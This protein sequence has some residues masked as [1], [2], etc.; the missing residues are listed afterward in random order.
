MLFVPN[1]HALVRE[2]LRELTVI[3][4]SVALGGGG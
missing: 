2:P 4:I 1:E 3:G